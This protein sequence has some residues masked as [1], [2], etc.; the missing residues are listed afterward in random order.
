MKVYGKP[1][2][3]SFEGSLILRLP[4]P[5]SLLLSKMTNP[6]FMITWFQILSEFKSF[7]YI[8]ISGSNTVKINLGMEVTKKI[9][10]QKIEMKKKK[11]EGLLK[12]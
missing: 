9:M 2:Y 5:E 10:R 11:A 6:Q 3:L 8:Y 7:M 1:H 4:C 12:Y